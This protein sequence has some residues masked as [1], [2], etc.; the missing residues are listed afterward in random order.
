MDEGQR[1]AASARITH[2]SSDQVR[3]RDGR[4]LSY[5]EWGDPD[6]Y[7]V[8]FFH[9]TPGSRVCVP[10]ESATSA[11]EIR[12]ITVDRPGYGRSSPHPG[13]TLHDWTED[14]TELV[15]ALEIER[16]AVVGL[17][18]GGPHA[19]ACAVALPDRIPNVGVISGMGLLEAPDATRGMSL[20]NRVGFRLTRHAPLVLRVV[21]WPTARRAQTHPLAVVE[22]LREHFAP[23]DR[24]VTERSE[25][26]A[27]MADE[28]TEAYRQG[29]QGHVADL[30]AL[31]RSWAFTLESIT[32][33]VRFWHGGVDRTA[34]LPMAEHLTDAIPGARLTIFPDEGHL[35]AY[36]HFHEILAAV[37]E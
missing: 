14:V 34:P 3:L 18:G 30:K 27:A 25:I 17:S 5:A 10:D 28:L 32:V 6:G 22:R 37:T 8:L 11:N 29:P 7:P 33:P 16:F 2:L 36:E 15:D 13:R 19:L 4:T 9:G 21:L 35:V 24:R 1:L 12:L 31:T 23:P 26:R 20:Y